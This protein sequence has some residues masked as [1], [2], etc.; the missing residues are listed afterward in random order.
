MSQNSIHCPPHSID[1]RRPLIGVDWGTS[2]LRAALIHKGQVLE[3]RSSDQGIMRITPGAFASVLGEL[4]KTWLD[5]EDVLILICGMAGSAQGWQLAPYCPCPATAQDVVQ[6]LQWVNPHKIAIVPGLSTRGVHAPDVMR[7][8]EVQIMGALSI[9]NTQNAKV[10]LP[11]TH[12][13]WVS[14]SSGRIEHFKTYMTGELY[15]IL[16]NHSILSKTLP[17][18]GETIDFDAKAFE[19][20]LAMSWGSKSAAKRPKSKSREKPSSTIA[21]EETNLLHNLFGI[22]TQALFEQQSAAQ[23]LN[24]LSGILIGQELQ[25]QHLEAEEHVIV[26]GS[27]ELQA[28]Y[29][30]ALQSKGVRCTLL[31]SQA[32]WQGLQVIAQEL[33]RVHPKL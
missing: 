31:G 18:E 4:C 5:Q 24:Q 13:K 11:G 17:T 32:T 30:H 16:K 9:L 23:L 19:Q 27:K 2:S 12:S 20:G 15:A 14:V 1:I 28:R 29:S 8:E 7:G 26:I 21:H 33:E 3:E 25:D 10:V 6:Q 22:R